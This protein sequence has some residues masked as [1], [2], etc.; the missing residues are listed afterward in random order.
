MKDSNQPIKQSNNEVQDVDVNQDVND[1]GVNERLVRKS[2]IKKTNSAGPNILLDSLRSNP[3][4]ST[5]MTSFDFLSTKGFYDLPS[6]TF[7]CLLRNGH[8]V[9]ER[10]Q[11]QLIERLNLEYAGTTQNG[12][13]ITSDAIESYKKVIRNTNGEISIPFQDIL[14]NWKGNTYLNIYRD[15]AVVSDEELTDEDVLFLN[16]YLDLMGKGIFGL[17]TLDIEKFIDITCNRSYPSRSKHEAPS[18]EELLYFFFTWVSAIYHRPGINLSTV[19]SFF[20]LPGTGKS[21]IMKLVCDLIGNSKPNVSQTAT[22][23]FNSA[24]ENT[25]VVCFNEVQEIPDF[26][27]NIIKGTLTEETILIERKGKDVY[28]V[29]NISNGII[30]CNPGKKSIKID[31]D[32]RR[33]VVINGIT[34]DQNQQLS[35]P[36]S[37]LMSDFLGSNSHRFDEL[38]LAFAKL[39]RHIDYD[40]TYLNK[41]GD[42]TT[43]G[44]KLL[45]EAYQSPV[46]RFFEDYSVP[47]IIIDDSKTRTQMKRTSIKQLEN[48]FK[49]WIMD[50]TGLGN[51]S[52][53]Y[54]KTNQ[55]F[56]QEVNALIV[57]G[58][59][60][61]R[62][63][64]SNLFF[65][66]TFYDDYLANHEEAQ[67]MDSKVVSLSRQA[68]LSRIKSGDV[69]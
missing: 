7:K 23:K 17:D 56:K 28:Q 52:A 57:I 64:N 3:S 48:L 11:S 24:F 33:L 30:S 36:I 14:V 51:V 25:L 31:S 66:D 59:F 13:V 63:S 8:V 61:M 50:Q 19:P 44:K 58:K 38:V 20:G 37:S 15:Q 26:Y 21:T 65:T 35:Q 47:F 29:P 42:L 10:C 12:N 32:D 60:V 18:N 53:N 55:A 69:K 1:V 5:I 54:S 16:E 27:N 22:G 9:P 68:L 45:Q 49:N 41:G 34:H 67:D 39:I 4:F 2:G 6:K 46:E 62:D 40:L 43:P